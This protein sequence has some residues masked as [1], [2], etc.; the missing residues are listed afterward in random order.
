MMGLPEKKK[1]HTVCV[2][3]CGCVA[4]KRLVQ[5]SLWLFNYLNAMGGLLG[6]KHLCTV[7]KRGHSNN[8]IDLFIYLFAYSAECQREKQNVFLFCSEL[9]LLY[10]AVSGAEK[11]CLF[12]MM[13][14]LGCRRMKGG[15]QPRW[16][17]SAVISPTKPAKPSTLA[18][19]SN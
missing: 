4:T 2:C 10:F 13:K 9:K 17:D 12:L 6:M 5:Q 8:L 19:S 1:G 18:S 3:L 14:T 7:Q 15:N 11:S 16:S